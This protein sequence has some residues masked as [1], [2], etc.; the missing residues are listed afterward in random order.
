MG[1]Y[2]LT[3]SGKE[4][5]R[6]FI[7]ECAAK[8]KEILDVGKDTASETQ[9]PTEDQILA[10]IN[11]NVED[12]DDYWGITDNCEPELLFLEE[13]VDFVKTSTRICVTLEKTIRVCE[14]FDATPE[15]MEMI[16]KGENPFFAALDGICTEEIGEVEY[17]Y[18]IVN[19]DTGAT[20][21]DWD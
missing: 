18:A 3:E 9:L 19:E 20:L 16:E 13:S 11:Q 10:N 4:R 12:G 21:I 1:K 15:D 6:T 5:I 7:N 14:Y 17:D 8:R 2:I